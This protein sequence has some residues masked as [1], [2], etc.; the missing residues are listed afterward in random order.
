[1]RMQKW[2]TRF[3]AAA[4]CSAFAPTAFAWDHPAHMTTAAIAFIEIEQSKP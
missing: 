2:I 4:L 1:M 3:M